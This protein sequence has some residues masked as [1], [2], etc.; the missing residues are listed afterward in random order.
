MVSLQ[1]DPHN[2]GFH[3]L[4]WSPT[5]LNKL[6]DVFVFHLLVYTYDTLCIMSVCPALKLDLTSIILVLATKINCLSLIVS[7]SSSARR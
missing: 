3:P 7:S 1:R 5:V 4:D 6:E 2:W